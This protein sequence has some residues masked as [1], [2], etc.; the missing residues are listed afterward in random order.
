MANS[1][2]NH[3]HDFKYVD[4]TEVYDMRAKNPKVIRKS[5]I[6]WRSIFHLFT[7]ISTIFSTM[8]WM[9]TIRHVNID[10][11]CEGVYLHVRLRFFY[12]GRRG[13]RGITKNII[14]VHN[15]SSFWFVFCNNVI[16]IELFTGENVTN[17]L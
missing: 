2:T 7:M 8:Q 6:C 17:I 4:L 9:F 11:S 15:N 13:H 5:K 3:N 10:R 12:F 1:E 14:V 16:T